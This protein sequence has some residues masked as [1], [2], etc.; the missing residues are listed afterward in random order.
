MFLLFTLMLL[1]SKIVSTSQV[2]ANLHCFDGGAPPLLQFD[3]CI[4]YGKYFRGEYL[5]QF[6]EIQDVD[7]LGVNVHCLTLYINIHVEAGEYSPWR[8]LTRLWR[9]NTASSKVHHCLLV[10]CYLFVWQVLSVENPCHDFAYAFCFS[11]A[12]T[13]EDKLF[14]VFIF[15]PCCGC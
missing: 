12:T 3:C 11:Y 1:L 5:P 13:A 8:A 7:V 2:L 10:N 14:F 4:W 15:C 9:T 6:C